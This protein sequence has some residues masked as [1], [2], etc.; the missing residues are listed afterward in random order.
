MSQ[1]ALKRRYILSGAAAAAAVMFRQTNA[2]W[3]VFVL[4][5][6]SSFE[7]ALERL[8]GQEMNR[9]SVLQYM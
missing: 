7:A 3:T 4:M 8:F 6:S 2:V 5:V 9:R 1:A